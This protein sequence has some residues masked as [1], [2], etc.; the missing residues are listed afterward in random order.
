MLGIYI[1]W[2]REIIRFFRSKSRVVGSLGMPFFFLAI[3][4][5]GLNNAF[6][7]P[8]QGNYLQFITPGIIGMVLMFGSMFSGITVLMDRQFGFLK[9]TLVA[10][11]SRTSIVI[12]KALGGA[13]T[14]IVQGA[15]ILG[16]AMLLGA[17]VQPANIALLAAFMVLISVAFVSLGTAIAS[18]MED[19]HGF[20]LIMNFLI[21]PLF[22]LSG[23][24]FPLSSAP[25]FLQ[26]ASMLDPL[27]Y[28]VDGL[29]FLLLGSSEIP[30]AVSLAVLTGFCAAFI[31]LAAFLF[32]R[33]EE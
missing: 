9:E 24:L 22:F 14:A 6:A 31:A 5:T 17:Q 29:R 7:I 3:L 20:Q 23:A 16:V 32:S 28:G 27:T 4:G 1:L 15:I 26:A 12:G 33:I 10:P 25:E 13:T 11:I 19:M 21:M 30:F 2:R 18:V 8:G